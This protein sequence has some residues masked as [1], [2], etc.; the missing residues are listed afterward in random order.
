MRSCKRV[1]LGFDFRLRVLENKPMLGLLS[2]D[3]KTKIMLKTLL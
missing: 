1:E 2:V 3:M